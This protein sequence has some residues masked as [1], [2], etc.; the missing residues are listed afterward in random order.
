[1]TEL[2]LGITTRWAAGDGGLSAGTAGIDEAAALEAMPGLGVHEIEL[3]G[4]TYE[5]ERVGSRYCSPADL[6]DYAKRNNDAFADESKYPDEK[7]LAAIQAAEEAIEECTGRS[8]CA[9]ARK[10]ALRGGGRVEELPEQDVRSLGGGTLLGDRQAVS[11]GPQE[12]AM[13]Y[14][15]RCTESIRRA[16][17]KLAASY[18][19]ARVGAENARGQSVDGVYISYELATGEDGSWT[20]LPEVDAVI[21]RNKSTRR[22]VA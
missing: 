20:G 3:G 17:C 11:D 21:A 6:R 22:I 15:A 18:L 14:G 8:F 9:R 12:V 4:A 19:R 5:V 10:V 2:S 13:E 16:A 1:M 7:L